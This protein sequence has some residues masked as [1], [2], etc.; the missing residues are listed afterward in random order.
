LQV[1]GSVKL[2][3]M[4]ASTSLHQ[5]SFFLPFLWLYF[6]PVKAP[7]LIGPSNATHKS[8]VFQNNCWFLNITE[9]LLSIPL[10]HLSLR[11]TKVLST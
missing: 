11:A 8:W 4:A 10:H 2:F 9:F 7:K 3:T 6:E 5:K 1:L